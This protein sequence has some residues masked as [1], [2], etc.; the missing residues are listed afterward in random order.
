M[1]VSLRLMVARKGGADAVQCGTVPEL[2][3][4]GDARCY[5]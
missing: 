3:R 1:V 5:P 4:A 2:F